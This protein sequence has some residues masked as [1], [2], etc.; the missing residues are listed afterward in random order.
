MGGG[1]WSM[2]MWIGSHP[3]VRPCYLSAE[4]GIK[5]WQT[6]DRDIANEFNFSLFPRPEHD[7]RTMIKHSE[8]RHGTDEFDDESIRMRDYKHLPG[9]IMRWRLMYGDKPLPSSW[10]WSFYPDGKVWKNGLEEY[11][12]E[13]VFEILTKQFWPAEGLTDAVLNTTNG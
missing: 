4:P 3:S 6:R 13:K 2:E 7:M 10:M 11:G 8:P 1:R 5:H 9:M 12:G